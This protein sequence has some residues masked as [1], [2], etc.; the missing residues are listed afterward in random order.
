MTLPNGISHA[1]NF[2]FISIGE[3]LAVEIPSP[4]VYPESFL[5]RTNEISTL[6]PPSIN[7]TIKLLSKINKRKPSGLDKI[8]CRLLKIAANII[9]PSLY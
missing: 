6:K 2:H 4:S 7:K 1:F 3:K 9:A 5:N 8:P